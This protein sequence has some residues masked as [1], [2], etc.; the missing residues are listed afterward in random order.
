M[1]QAGLR[2]GRDGLWDDSSKKPQTDHLGLQVSFLVP[3]LGSWP[4]MDGGGEVQ[5][6]IPRA[7]VLAYLDTAGAGTGVLE[8][9][10][11]VHIQHTCS[12][13]CVWAAG[14]VCVA[15]LWLL[16]TEYAAFPGDSCSM[17]M[18]YMQAPPT[19]SKLLGLR[20]A[21]RC[22]GRHSGSCG[23]EC[24]PRSVEQPEE[25][26]LI[27]WQVPRRGLSTP[28]EKTLSKFGPGGN[29]SLVFFL[30]FYLPFPLWK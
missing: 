21:W 27:P 18:W 1:K 5:S 23:L 4:S 26:S 12:G 14:A 3:G 20:W 6:A 10:P 25:V 13:G 24:P 9:C 28:R 19:S 17:F 11:L 30:C 2:P 29:C 16:S 22:S 8:A 15:S 7:S